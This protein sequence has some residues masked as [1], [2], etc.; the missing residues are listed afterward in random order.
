[1]CEQGGHGRR[2]TGVREGLGREALSGKER[3][4]GKGDGPGHARTTSG[5]RLRLLGAF[6]LTQ[7]LGSSLTITGYQAG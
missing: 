3:G 4:E 5:V 2:E 1:M 6:F 7:N